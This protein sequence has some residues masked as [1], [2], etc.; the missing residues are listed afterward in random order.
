M[1]YMLKQ[2]SYKLD[3]DTKE[4]DNDDSENDELIDY[5][6]DNYIRFLKE[7]SKE[8]IKSLLG[9][10]L[11]ESEIDQEFSFDILMNLLI[12]DFEV[13]TEVLLEILNKSNI[14]GMTSVMITYFEEDS[15]CARKLLNT[16]SLSK[17]ELTQ[18]LTILTL[19]AL[20][21]LKNE[22]AEEIIINYFL[23]ENIIQNRIASESIGRVLE[24]KPT[25]AEPIITNL[26][27]STNTTLKLNGIF[28]TQLYVSISPE[29]ANKF[30]TKI[31]NNEN[32]IIQLK[33]LL[34][35]SYKE[36]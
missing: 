7:R 18:N 3:T 4:L 15:Q 21:L 20:F 29:E 36:S 12:E 33:E 24:T 34:E 10:S 6:L 31:T 35:D 16:L 2:L 22:H 17:K 25:Y 1:H 23:S 8:T 27:K 19:K 5:E 13:G 30:I 28:L 26:L 32:P 14:K 11:S 9:L